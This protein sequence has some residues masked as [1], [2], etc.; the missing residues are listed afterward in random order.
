[1]QTMTTEKSSNWARA[2][3]TTLQLA[4]VA[5]AGVLLFACGASANVELMSSS[6]HETSPDDTSARPSKRLLVGTWREVR[7]NVLVRFQRDGTFKIGNQLSD[8]FAIGTYT[9]SGNL[10]RFKP[11]GPWCV[12]P[13]VWKAS[14]RDAQRRLGNELDV[15][16][17]TRACDVAKKTKW[18]FT[19]IS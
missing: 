1:M 11:V 12:D 18:Q 7:E 14:V 2:V 3:A 15:Y 6:R 9:L 16:F 19:R 17:V 5:L 8:P 13:W 10:V 4:A